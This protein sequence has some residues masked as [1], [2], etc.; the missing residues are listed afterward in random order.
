[1]LA[2]IVLFVY[3]RPGHTRKTVE[4]LANNMLA[5]ESELFI[6]SDYPKDAA[7][8][9]K[10]KEVREFI[11]TVQGFK[12]ITIVERN[13]NLGLAASIIDGVTHIVNQYGKIIVLEDDIVTSPYFLT[14]MN[15]AL[16]L[17]ENDQ[18][19]ISIHGY[20][21]PVKKELPDFFF[22]KG[23]DCWGWSTWKRGWD[24]FNPDGEYLLKE[25]KRKNLEK[26]F[27]FNDS[28]DFTGMLQNQINGNISSWAIR[29]Y[30]SA[31]L[32]NK[33]TLYPGK[34]LVENIG[35]DGTGTHCGETERF[36]SNL[37]SRYIPVMLIPVENSNKAKKTF[38]QYFH[39]ISKRNS[40]LNFLGK[41]N[42]MIRG[43]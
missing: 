36:K 30:A 24:I 17:Y 32:A 41:I 6:Y 16:I 33:Y 23:A 31:F 42:T 18:R 21:Y 43:V 22:L 11:K 37:L 1:M 29:W 9:D 10:V 2:P 35:F 14:F 20:V 34:S 19:V 38:A 39:S 28:F 26:E 8:N 3:N 13:K 40:V 5:S 15:D 7:A 4:A 27:N 12:S 25:T